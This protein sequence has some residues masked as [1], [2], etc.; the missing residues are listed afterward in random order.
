MLEFE[1][2]INAN[3]LPMYYQPISIDVYNE[4]EFTSLIKEYVGE[5]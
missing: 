5:I 2:Y 1:E 3:K 4:Q